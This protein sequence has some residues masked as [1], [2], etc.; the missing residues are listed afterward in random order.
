MKLAKILVPL[1]LLMALALPV[2][3][4]TGNYMA[5]RDNGLERDRKHSVATSTSELNQPTLNVACIQAAVD[6]RDTAMIAA[7]DAHALAV[8]AAIS[9]RKNAIKAAWALTD[10]KA[11]RDALRDAWK[12]FKDAAKAARKAY[13]D[14]RMAAW[15]TYE[16]DRKACGK[17]ATRDD[18]TGRGVDAFSE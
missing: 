3:A 14:A 10:R 15:Q 4:Q 12:V 2:I 7:V 9:A 11:R 17:Q 16:T 5:I 8:K 18:S 13:R 6:K 1:A